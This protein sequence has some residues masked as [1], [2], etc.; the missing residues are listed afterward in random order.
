VSVRD[1]VTGPRPLRALFLYSRGPGLTLAA[2]PA[3]ATVLDLMPHAWAIPDDPEAAQRRFALLADVAQRVP[4]F[5]LTAGRDDPPGAI[6]DVLRRTL[7]DGPTF[8]IAP[9]SGV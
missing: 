6:A 8:G 5:W 3:E 2:E 9:R 7:R 4:V 1:A